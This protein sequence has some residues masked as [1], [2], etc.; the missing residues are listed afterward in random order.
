MSR[1]EA[2]VPFTPRAKQRRLTNLSF[3][4]PHRS[5]HHKRSA[6]VGASAAAGPLEQLRRERSG[7]LSMTDA[8]PSRS[9]GASDAAAAR[10]ATVAA[11][12]V[13]PSAHVAARSAHPEP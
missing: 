12:A 8:A 5:R 3:P 4:A 7:R 2:G 10:A 9:R 11:T 13:A 1:D 6:T